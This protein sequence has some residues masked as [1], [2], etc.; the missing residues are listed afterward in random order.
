MCST[1]RT[2]SAAGTSSPSAAV[3]LVDFSQIRYAQCWEDA[4]VLLSALSVRPGQVCLSIASAGDNTLALLSKSPA[5]VIALDVSRPQLACL[6]LR[7][8][9]YRT[10]RHAELLELVGSVAS[11]RRADL[12]RRCRAAL[13]P[14]TRAFW[15]ATP[16]LIASGIGS[17]GR[18]ERYLTLFRRLILPLVHD[19][20]CVERLLRGG[21]ATERRE[22]YARGWDTARWR[23]FFRLFFSQP[24]MARLGRDPEFFRHATDRVSTHLLAQ[25]RHALVE[26]DPAT[27]PYLHWILTGMHGT[28]L[29]YALRPEN[30]DAIRANLDRLE[31]RCQSLEEFLSAA[32]PASIDRFNL[33]DVFEYMSEQEHGVVLDRLVR[34]ARGGARLAYWNMLVPRSRPC[35][36][37]EQLL[38]LD[39]LAERLH[40]QDK[41]FFYRR[42]VIE[43]V[44]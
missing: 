44:A 18:F 21:T 43:E 9:A 25:V 8:A 13:S 35:R 5:H 16:A 17:A 24:V 2:R 29:P 7:V 14:G 27:N 19:R 3:Q 20:A 32:E 23:L 42:F 37:A 12:Y 10:L 26:Q 4:D 39:E 38:S 33:S 6:E 36:L 15:D 1:S 34:A 28:T 11:G 22:S 30:F 31:W 40:G 41:V